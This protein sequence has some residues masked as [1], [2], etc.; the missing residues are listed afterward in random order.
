MPSGR[1]S[2]WHLYPV[3]IN[4]DEPAPLRR[5]V[6]EHLRASGIGINVHYEPVYRHSS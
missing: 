6:F 2:G 1:T 5:Q 3:R 4:G